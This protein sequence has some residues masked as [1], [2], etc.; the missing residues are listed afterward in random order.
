MKANI[1][2]VL[3]LFALMICSIVTTA[4]A[5]TFT[6]TVATGHPSIIPWV[7]LLNSYFIPD[8]DKR[9]AI[10]GG[11]YKILW[12]KAY[13]G[14]VAKIGGVL[15]AIEQGVADLG[16]VGAVFEP[17][18]LP[19]Q[20]VSYYTP[21]ATTKITTAV[22]VIDEMHHKVP[23]LK[24]TWDKYNQVYLTGLGVDNFNLFTKK[25]IKSLKDIKGMKIGGAGPNLNWLRGAG[26]V[27]V[28]IDLTT[29]YNDLATGIYDGVLLFPSSAA[30]IKVHEVAPY[31]LQVG[32]GAMS[33]AGLTVNKDFWNSLPK[34]VQKVF[35]AAANDYRDK[36]NQ[37]QK[38]L[39]V[40]G[41]AE[42]VLKGLKVSKLTSVERIRWAMSMPNIAK[43]W[44]NS[45]EAKGL[46]AKEVIKIWLKGVR[47]RG[48]TPVRA[49][50]KEL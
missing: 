34:E 2:K 6:V 11:N 50:D 25:P 46:P 47:A 19:L 15:E 29:I 35:L 21:F 28:Q 42:M 18:N 44:S 20:I 43:E 5:K 36:L 22:E 38:E 27:G 4:S 14:T 16:I 32:F 9:L 8:V 30:A 23:A 41:L 17:A 39:G 24:K 33:W 48:E 3:V 12:R 31:Y 49:W 45:L 37:Y 26:V 13:G 1:W 7:K 40:K 10:S